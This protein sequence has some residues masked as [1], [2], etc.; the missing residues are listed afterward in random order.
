ML[1]PF[2]CW[3]GG[4][5]QHTDL[6]VS[7]AGR[8]E[9]W[10]MQL[11]YIQ[12][13]LQLLCTFIN[14]PRKCPVSAIHTAKVVEEGF[15]LIFRRSY[16]ILCSTNSVFAIRQYNL[17]VGAYFSLIGYDPKVSHLLA[18]IA[19][20]IADVMKGFWMWGGSGLKINFVDFSVKKS[21][22]EFV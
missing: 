21:S 6:S 14:G 12:W 2:S 8:S 13:M 22:F 4:L 3:G 17:R 10:M 9:K 7:R 19:I 20:S 16:F 1:S 5:N 18:R 11:L 15:K